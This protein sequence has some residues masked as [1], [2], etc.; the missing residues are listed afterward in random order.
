MNIYTEGLMVQIEVSDE[1]LLSILRAL[2]LEYS[3]NKGVSQEQGAM[4]CI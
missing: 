1:S 4:T 3:A 2:D